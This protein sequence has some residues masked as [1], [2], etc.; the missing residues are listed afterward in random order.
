MFSD[1]EKEA[2][3]RKAFLEISRGCSVA[4]YNDELLYIKHFNIFD[5]ERLDLA[6][7]RKLKKLQ[8][9]GISS[10]ADRLKEI[11]EE[12]KWGDKQKK[13]IAEKEVFI[14]NLQNTKKALVIP[15]Q[16]AQIDEKLKKCEEEIAKLYAERDS[17]L[18]N[19]AEYF[20]NRYLNDISIYESFYKDEQL[21]N[22]FFSQDEFED[23]ERK[24]IYDLVRIY[25]TS[26]EHISVDVI[27]HLAL[28][29][30]FVN[31]FNINE[32]SPNELFS[33]SPLDLT[34]YQVNLITYCK[35][36]KSIFKNIPEINDDIKDDP[37][38]LLELAEGGGKA[39]EKIDEI[40]K[41]AAKGNQSRAQ[42]IVG[43]SKSDLKDMGMEQEG[44]ISIQDFLK[45]K[46]KTSFSLVQDGDIVV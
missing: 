5:Q 8:K 26:F 2:K 29:G 13:E 30:L 35:I 14:K 7:Q 22:H 24:E 12:G 31:Y 33:R 36:F 45:Q 46:G 43:A 10:E 21:E 39:Q 18:N 1:K 42:S 38:K 11:E 6:Y 3:L 19:T 37:D 15:A 20:A 40:K 44:T 32:N 41:I 28:S 23:L 4:E 9:Q 17:L 27:K 25:N 34:F 16:K